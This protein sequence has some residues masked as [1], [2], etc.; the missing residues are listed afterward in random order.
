MTRWTML[1]GHRMHGPASSRLSNRSLGH[2]A[3]SGAERQR[4]APCFRAS[5]NPTVRRK[6][7]LIVIGIL[8]GTV[9]LAGLAVA[10]IAYRQAREAAMS[11]CTGVPS[12]VRK[13]AT[14]VTVE[15]RVLPWKVT[16]VFHDTSGRVVA[17]APAPYDVPWHN[18]L[19]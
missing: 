15:S 5:D 18:L 1:R 11:T 10:A 7:V 6:A 8:A 14:S 13:G 16:C 2:M 12:E 3:T 4:L 9:M 17:K 19:P